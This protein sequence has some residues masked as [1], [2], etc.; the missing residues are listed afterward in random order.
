[1]RIALA[2]AI[3]AWG[4]DADLEPLLAA[5]ARAGLAAEA[6][7]WDDPSVSWSRFDAV[8]LRST[9]DYARRRPEFLA[10]CEQVARRTRLFNPPAT[11]RWNTDKHYLADLAA[12][13]VPIVPTAFIENERDLARISTFDGEFVLKPSVGAGARGAARFAAHQQAEAEAHARRLLEDGYCVMLQPYLAGVDRQGETALIH[14][15]GRYS[16]A[17]RKGPLLAPGGTASE[18]LFAPEDIQPRIASEA[19]HAVAERVLAALPHPA[20]YA[21]VDLLPGPQGPLLL[22]LELVEPSLFFACC[23]DAADA[24]VAALQAALRAG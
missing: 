8:L 24:L 1:M 19:E 18:A 4:R 13:G 9:W 11:V 7:A 5:C 15:H 23:E 20:L 12:R 22:E 21:R 2:T 17:I 3:A 16:H 6:L 14:I 10:W